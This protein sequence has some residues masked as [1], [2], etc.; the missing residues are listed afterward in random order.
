MT[1]LEDARALAEYLDAYAPVESPM[2]SDSLHRRAAT[3]LRALADEHERL[4]DE[5]D[6]LG[7]ACLEHVNRY[8]RLTADL[9][10]ARQGSFTGQSMHAHWQER[11]EKAD[12][13]VERLTER[14]A[15]HSKLGLAAI[16]LADT[17]PEGSDPDSEMSKIRDE[18]LAER[19]TAPPT[20]DEREA[21]DR[22]LDEHMAVRPQRVREWP[23]DE[24]EAYRELGWS[25]GIA[26][27]RK[28]QVA[29]ARDAILASDVWRNRRQAPVTDAMLAA[30]L[31]AYGD[32]STHW[33]S[34]VGMR[35]AL[36]A[37]QAANYTNGS[38][39]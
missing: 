17:F 39:R 14:V 28:L 31:N 3:A 29:K 10:E 24:A 5:R 34:G 25:E 30:A 11:A 15:V 21:L 18:W 37:A 26:A 32:V 12:A 33:A 4:T 8:E 1:A 6:A 16:F 20:D 23:D 35:D 2:H 38:E 27:A 19:L 13:E 9:H 36:E 22:L 7:R